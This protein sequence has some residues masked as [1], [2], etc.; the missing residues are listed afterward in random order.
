MLQN[1]LAIVL[2]LAG[3]AVRAGALSTMSTLWQ[4][5][6]QSTAFMMQHFYA[7]LISPNTTK[8]EALHR[9]QL[10]LLHDYGDKSP[11]IWAPY[12]L[13]GNWL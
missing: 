13:V 6:D 3:I 2:G 10:A 8:A 12:V 4:I 11:F 7:E 9:A 1:F 5:S